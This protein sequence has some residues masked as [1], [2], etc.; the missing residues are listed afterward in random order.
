M[1]RLKIGDC[2]KN[3]YGPKVSVIMG[4]YNCEATLSQSV[5]SI[6][7]QTYLNWELIICDDASDDRSYAIASEYVKKDSR[8]RLLRNKNNIKLGPTLNRCLELADGKYTA[9]MDGDD[10]SEPERFQ[11]QINFLENN[12]AYAVVGCTMKILD[13]NGISRLR[14]L[15]QK[16]GITWLPKN[17]PCFHATIVMRTHVYKQLEGY[18]LSPKTERVEDYDLFWRLYENGYKAYNLSEALY[19]MREPI[20]AYDRRKFKFSLNASRLVFIGCRKMHLSLKYY[21][22]IF[23]P[24]IS[25]MLPRK[26]MHRYHYKRDKANT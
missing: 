15:P 23:K 19:I 17:N 1:K 21:I 10:I 5:E 6:I 25:G 14:T 26:I 16:P 2:Q 8:I 7:G 22:F 3:E 20:R 24:L 18:S 12:E 4:I 13:D 9:R 11:K